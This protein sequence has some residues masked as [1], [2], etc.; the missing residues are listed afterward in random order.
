MTTTNGIRFAS[1]AIGVAALM[2]LAVSPAS[3]A[4]YPAREMLADA[5]SAAK[6]A[7]AIE[8]IAPVGDG[9]LGTIRFG[10][11]AGTRGAWLRFGGPR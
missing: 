5:T 4:A 7:T 8:I 11:N 1:A 3:L 10:T 6:P 2:T 9:A